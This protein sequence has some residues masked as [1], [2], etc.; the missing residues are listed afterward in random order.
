MHHTDKSIK[1]IGYDLGFNEPA[2]FS[3]LFKKVTGK[4]PSDFQVK[5]V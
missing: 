4:S 3:R 1:E 5:I 2:Q